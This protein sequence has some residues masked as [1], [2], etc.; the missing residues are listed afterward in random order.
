ML[1]PRKQFIAK[2]RME[3]RSGEEAERRRQ[4]VER[5]SVEWMRAA[6]KRERERERVNVCESVCVCVWCMSMW[7]VKD[8]MS[9]KGET[10]W[11]YGPLSAFF[12][13]ALTVCIFTIHTKPSSSSLPSTSIQI[14]MHKHG[15]CKWTKNPKMVRSNEL[16]TESW[17]SYWKRA[18][19]FISS[20]NSTTM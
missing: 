6:E 1:L 5:A 20:I 7:V 17:E 13:R 11:I 14:P 3:K 15:T 16:R 12:Y 2:I 4:N 19:L 9:K 8:A 18:F 10:L